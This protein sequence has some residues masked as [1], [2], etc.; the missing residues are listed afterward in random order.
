MRGCACS[1]ARTAL[2][3]RCATAA[4]VAEREL[5]YRSARI[6]TSIF[7]LANASAS[8]TDGLLEGCGAWK[9]RRSAASNAG[10]GIAGAFGVTLDCTLQE[11]IA[12]NTAQ[13]MLAT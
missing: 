3:S 13:P 1:A 12:C 11:F 5:R 7:E 6:S 8:A 9:A 4:R 2:T 10:Y